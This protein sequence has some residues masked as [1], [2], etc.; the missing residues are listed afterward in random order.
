[1][2]SPEA[3]ILRILDRVLAVVRAAPQDLSWQ[4]RY[5]DEQEL[6]DDLSDYAGR[7][8]LHDLSRL[9]ELRFVFAPTGSLCEIA[10]S[11]GW[12]DL[13][14]VL[15]NRFDELYAQLRKPAGGA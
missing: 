1:M 5:S 15:G 2:E 4:R 7:L 14:T 9:D 10:A 13:Y 8:R 11:S 3:E 6:I 12:L